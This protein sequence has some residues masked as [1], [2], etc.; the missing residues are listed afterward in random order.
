MHFFP[1]C[2][3]LGNLKGRLSCATSQTARSIHALPI[4]ANFKGSS[5]AILLAIYCR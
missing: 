4:E 5:G 2:Q 1:P 3:P